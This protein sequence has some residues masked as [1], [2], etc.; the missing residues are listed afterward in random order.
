MF[1]GIERA[2]GC[3]N[4]AERLRDVAT[5]MLPAAYTPGREGW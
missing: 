4:F 3:D 1:E 2:E 5:K